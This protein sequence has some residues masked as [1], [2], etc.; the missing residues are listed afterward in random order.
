MDMRTLAAPLGHSKLNIAMRHVHPQGKHQADAMRLLEPFNAAKEIAEV[1]K[2]KQ[3]ERH[4]KKE[5]VPTASTTVPE[6]RP[7]QQE[8]ETAVN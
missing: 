5:V 7:T 1:E 3:A 8:A 6:N 4:A 2:Q